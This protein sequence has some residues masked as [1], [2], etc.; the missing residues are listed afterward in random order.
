MINVNLDYRSKK[1]KTN[2]EIRVTFKEADKWRSVRTR[3]QL[4]VSKSFWNEY[5]SGTNFRD[6]EK[7]NKA[8]EIDDLQRS[9]SEFIQDRFKEDASIDGEW[10]KKVVHEFYNPIEK[11]TIP[12]NLTE[13]WDQYLK[14]RQHEMRPQSYQ[15]WIQTKKKI[16]L[17]EKKTDQTVKIKDVNEE[18]VRGWIECLEAEE[19]A[20]S[21][22][23]K[24]FIQ[25]KAVCMHAKI[26]GVPTSR[27]LETLTIKNRNANL[28][29]IY[30]SF[31]EI[32]KIRNLTNLSES[33]DNVR[34]WLVISCFVG[35]RISDFM[36]INKSMI[37]ETPDGR[38]IDLKQQKTGKDV[39]IP[40]LPEVDEILNK[41]DGNFPRRI[42]DQR[43]NDYL[44]EVCK[45]AG[46]DNPIQGKVKMVVD[47]RSRGVI[48]TYPKYQL[49]ASHV[50]RLSFATNF[51]GK[52]PT[53]YLMNITGHSEERTFLIYIG[54]T[55]KDTAKD[56]LN[57]MLKIDRR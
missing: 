24:G 13:Y 42:S 31:E 35:Q 34:D 22:I 36:R 51:Y 54:K 40:I 41:R 5:K 20:H 50:G 44:K 49:I 18:F 25:I 45:M 57:Q 28:P 43:Y 39:T 1:D 14:F 6:A 56:A 12:D 10:L 52:V 11:T 53:S 30:L 15:K 3:S 9:M 55:T 27:D 4:E 17:Y 2:L 37:R 33:L 32:E 23:R 26:K 46:I 19:Y 8:R 48:D 7:V 38:F 47:G 29:K 21:T 16:E